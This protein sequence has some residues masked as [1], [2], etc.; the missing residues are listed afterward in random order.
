M[1]DHIWKKAITY[2]C[3]FQCM[4]MSRREANVLYRACF[5]L[6]ITYSFPAM[7]L[8]EKFLERIQQLSTSTILNKMGL[9]QNLPRSLVFAP[10]AIGG[11][12]LCNLTHEQSVQQLLIVVRHLRAHT[13]LGT[14]LELLIRTYQL[15]AG[16][17]RHILEDTQP[18]PWIPN[19]WLSHLRQTMQRNCTQ[20]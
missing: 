19:H 14:A 20:I 12:G 1:E 18:C 15:W 11:M 6:A 4:H 13:T 8:S 9:H 16:L 5:L 17:S 2:T 3:A 10:R 7:W